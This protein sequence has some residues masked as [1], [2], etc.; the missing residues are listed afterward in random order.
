MSEGNFAKR[1]EINAIITWDQVNIHPLHKRKFQDLSGVRASTTAM[2][3]LSNVW[4]HVEIK[5]EIKETL[6]NCTKV[7]F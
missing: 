5:T 4:N 6:R 1:L 2:Q 7:E 3:V